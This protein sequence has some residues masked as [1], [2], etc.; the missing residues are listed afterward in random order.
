[1]KHILP[2]LAVL[3][4]SLTF[5]FPDEIPVGNIIFRGRL[6]RNAVAEKSSSLIYLRSN[7]D[8]Q[9]SLSWETAPNSL[10]A[11]FGDQKANSAWED[12][13]TPLDRTEI[14]L[15]KR[16]GRAQ[17]SGAVQPP[18]TR[19]LIYRTEMLNIEARFVEKQAGLF[20][21]SRRTG[22]LTS[23]EA[24]SF[25]ASFGAPWE[26]VIYGS[27]YSADGWA[28]Q[29][30]TFAYLREKS[31]YIQFADFTGSVSEEKKSKR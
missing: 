21:V 18:V 6:Y 10:R 13:A 2:I 3:L 20:I 11:K 8:G 22:A 17:A 7:Q 5:V 9:I 28:R 16:F 24:E 27:P 30:G 15:N 29:D 25:L 23:T 26:K 14:A 4:S 19:N 12:A 31:L 1:M